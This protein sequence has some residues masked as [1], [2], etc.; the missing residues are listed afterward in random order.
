[1]SSSD[2]NRLEE[3][4]ATAVAGS[5]IGQLAR[6]RD[7]PMGDLF[8]CG[9]LN[10]SPVVRELATELENL[11]FDPQ[12]L[13]SQSLYALVA[14]FAEESNADLITSQFTALLW[15]ILGDPK[16]GGS[17]P[18]IYRRAGVAMHLTLLGILDPS[19]VEKS[20]RS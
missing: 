4:L 12:L 2:P 20:S 18:E 1:M 9:L 13:A 8:A 6:K 15:S 11:G 5:L 16:N 14:L 19:I 10:P 7:I 3:Y 17:P